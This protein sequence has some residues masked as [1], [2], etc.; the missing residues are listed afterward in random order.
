MGITNSFIITKSLTDYGAAH[1]E[2]LIPVFRVSA[3]VFIYMLGM[4]QATGESGK[5]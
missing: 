2:T 5:I 1:H 4:S 3:L